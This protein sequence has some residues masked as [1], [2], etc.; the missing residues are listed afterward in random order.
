MRGA[1]PENMS[2]LYQDEGKGM[3]LSSDRWG[4]AQPMVYGSTSELVVLDTIRK[5]DEQTVEN[6]SVTAPHRGLWGSPCLRVSCLY[7]LQL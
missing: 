2:L 3:L 6:R 5:Q 4:S 7:F 1:S